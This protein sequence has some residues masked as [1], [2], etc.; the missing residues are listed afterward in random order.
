[1]KQELESFEQKPVRK[2]EY[3]GEMYYSVLDVIEHFT[4]TIAPQTEWARLKRRNFILL[5]MCK[6][7]KMKA[8]DGQTYT[9]D[10]LSKEGIFRL[11]MSIPSPTAEPFKTMLAGIGKHAIAETED[12]ELGFG[13]LPTIKKATVYRYAPNVL[14]APDVYPSLATEWLQRGVEED[15]FWLLNTTIMQW[16]FGL[17]LAKHKAL[18]GLKEENLCDHMTPLELIFTALGEEITRHIILEDD[19]QGFIENVG[20]AQ[21]GGSI[22]GNA[23][24]NF[25]KKSGLKVI[26]QENFLGLKSGE[27]TEES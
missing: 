12:P 5:R 21:K 13:R 23:R 11:L 3:K 26:S 7:L 9:T 10:A 20:A 8:L 22:A 1:M 15:A 27:S 18:K 24:R 6:P 14:T 19:A 16:T 17:S 4:K 2:V 25:E